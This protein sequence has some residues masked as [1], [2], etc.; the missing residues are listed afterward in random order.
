MKTR[1]RRRGG[2]GDQDQLNNL[3]VTPSSRPQH[4]CLSKTRTSQTE[5]LTMATQQ[6]PGLK[7]LFPNNPGVRF[8]FSTFP[9]TI[10]SLSRVQQVSQLKPHSR[11]FSAATRPTRASERG[12]RRMRCFRVCAGRDKGITISGLTPINRFEPICDM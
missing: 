3:L 1:L 5:P 10:Y 6:L 7:C 12:R 8:I 11:V 4:Q 2:S 9:T